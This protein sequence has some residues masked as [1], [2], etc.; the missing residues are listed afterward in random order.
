M[1]SCTLKPVFQQDNGTPSDEACRP[2]GIRSTPS[3]EARRPHGIRSTPSAEARRPH[4]IR[5][6]LSDEVQLR[7]RYACCLQQD[8]E[9]RQRLTSLA[10]LA[11][12]LQQD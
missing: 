4:G 2:R 3:A 11:C 1:L 6:T 9:Q 10:S 12:S 8:G 5:S 7:T